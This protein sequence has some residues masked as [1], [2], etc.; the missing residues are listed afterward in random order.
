MTKKYLDSVRK[1]LSRRRALQGMS[2]LVGTA[3]VGC[4]ASTGDGEGET[5]DTETG[6]DGGTDSDETGTTMASGDGD[7]DPGDGDGDDDGDDDGDGDGDGDPGDGDGDGD[8][9]CVDNTKLSVQ[10]ALV[11]VEHIIVLCMENRSFDHYF[12]AL[13]LEEEHPDVN[14]LSGTESNP[15]GQGNDILVNK[16]D[17]YEPLDPPHQWDEVHAQWNNG[18]LDG[19][20]TEHI[21]EHDD[22]VKHEV[23]GYHNRDDLPV[24]YALADNYT[25]CDAWHCS[26]L[27]GTWANRYYLHCATS[28]GGKQNVPAFL[29][30]TYTTIQDVCDDGG[31]SNN[32]YYAGIVPWRWGAFPGDFS[33]TDSFDE[34][35]E[36]IDNG[37]LEE[38][39]IIDPDFMSND[40]HPSHNI[41]LGQALI[42]TIYQALAQSQYWDKCLLVI[43]YDEHGGFY[44]HVV[45]GTTPD[46]EGPEFENQGFRVPS[47]VIGPHVRS[48]CVNHTVLD[49]ASFPATVTRKF[50][51]PELNS[52]TEN[53]NDLAS[54]IDP[55]KIDNPSPPA[56][57]PIVV[58][59]EKEVLAQCGVETSQEELM[60]V[61][62]NWPITPE[63]TERVRG[64]IK[65]LLRVGERLG[66]VKL[67]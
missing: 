66:A 18:A 5:G 21:A 32:N 38:V 56:P 25:L 47:V 13:Q 65:Q 12:G 48:G 28:N 1:L 40:D 41:M 52:R 31:I 67:V 35:F 19:F 53:V 63:M 30:F 36:N 4:T 37:V 59:P 33:G 22:S 46:D 42:A 3:A 62:G 15:D 20:V 39:V 23:M 29:P 43:T 45:P 49:H 58:I 11:N 44:D 9:A 34:F 10:E 51:L 8:D 50:G 54:C 64:Q 27:G 7:G 17:N 57:L 26:L 55:T 16:L 24:L 60:R 2:A 6:G 14:G 61:T